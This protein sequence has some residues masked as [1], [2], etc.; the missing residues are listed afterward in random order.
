MVE[1]LARNIH[2]FT[3]KKKTCEIALLSDL[4][5]DNPHC[6]RKLLKNHLDYLVCK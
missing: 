4:H 3:F 6:D 1:K 5:W 2:K